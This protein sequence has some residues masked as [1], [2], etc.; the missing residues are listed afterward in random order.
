MLEVSQTVTFRGR[1]P[2]LAAIRGRQ[3]VEVFTATNR[4]RPEYAGQAQAEL[5]TLGADRIERGFICGWRF[6]PMPQGDCET[7]EPIYF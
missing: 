1:G 7:P 4:L 3:V 6:C 2:V 5:K